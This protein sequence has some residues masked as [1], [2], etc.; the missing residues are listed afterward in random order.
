MNP[1]ISKLPWT[2]EEDRIILEEHVKLGNKW[3]EIATLLP[4]R[5]DNA[6]KNHWNSSMKRKVHKYM[7]S[8]GYSTEK[9]DLHGEID[10]VLEALRC[11]EPKRVVTPPLEDGI[12]AL[13]RVLDQ[14]EKKRP[15][16]MTLAEIK[17]ERKRHHPESPL[18]SLA[19]AA[20][21]LDEL[22]V[23]SPFRDILPPATPKRSSDFSPIFNLTSPRRRSPVQK[24]PFF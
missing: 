13:V 1:A 16:V 11:K 21:E 14:P 8:R 20:S 22:L 9:L 15:V 6:I 3:A 17:Q 4:G 2:E 5:T 24:M 23:T 7:K 12:D 18:S 19:A 10:Q